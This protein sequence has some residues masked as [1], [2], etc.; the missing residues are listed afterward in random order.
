MW[1]FIRPARRSI[2]TLATVTSLAAVTAAAAG[3]PEANWRLLAM[4]EISETVTDDGVWRADKSFPPELR[5]AREDFEIEGYFVPITSEPFVRTFLLVEDPAD[6]PY[7]GGGGYGPVLE[8]TLK[9]PLAELPEFSRIRVRGDL[10]FVEDPETMQ[11]TV[12]EDA[13]V[14]ER[15]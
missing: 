4:V 7:C 1:R 3:D 14:L 9:R 6:C 15:P 10:A 5:A 11:S 8:V 12:L 2:L 13:I